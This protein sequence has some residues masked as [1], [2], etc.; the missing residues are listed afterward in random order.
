MVADNL[1]QWDDDTMTYSRQDPEFDPDSAG[2][3]IEGPDG[4]DSIR[5]TII[6]ALGLELSV[7]NPA[8]AEALLAQSG[9]QLEHTPGFGPDELRELRAEAAQAVPDVLLATHTVRDEDESR[10]RAELRQRTTEHGASLGFDISPEGVWTSIK[11]RTMVVRSV[12][13][14]S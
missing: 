6:D 8:V 10:R 2:H 7:S 4:S 13:D 1:G 11:G 9:I 14:I 3:P 12:G 5:P